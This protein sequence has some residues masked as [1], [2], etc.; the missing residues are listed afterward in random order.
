MYKRSINGLKP[1]FYLY[2]LMQ[3]VPCLCWKLLNKIALAELNSY[4][5]R[6]NYSLKQAKLFKTSSNLFSLY[7]VIWSH[8]KGH[9][10]CMHVCVLIKTLAVSFWFVPRV[11]INRFLGPVPGEPTARCLLAR[12]KMSWYGVEANNRALTSEE[13]VDVPSWPR[14]CE[15]LELDLPE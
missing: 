10:S 12:C 14:L 2:F 9:V 4:S 1:P 5:I 7:V 3:F 8:R 15:Q 11:A 6:G 13:S